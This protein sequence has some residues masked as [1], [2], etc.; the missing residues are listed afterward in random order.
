MLLRIGGNVLPEVG[1]TK[2][3]EKILDSEVPGDKFGI[4]A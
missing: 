3:L 4:G 1:D 2:H